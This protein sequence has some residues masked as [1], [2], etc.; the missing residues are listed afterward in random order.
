[1][2][3]GR[4]RRP[5]PAKGAGGDP[6]A[7]ARP[8]QG[9]AVPFGGRM[10]SLATRVEIIKLAAALDADPAE[11]D[12]LGKLT[13]EAVRTVRTA[14]EEALFARHERRFRRIA[15]LAASVPPALAARVAQLALDPLLGARVAAVMEPA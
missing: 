8:S 10:T 6:P 5:G 9:A 7:P 15:K 3:G 4:G 12:H 13:P 2:G 11:L 14:L 1:R